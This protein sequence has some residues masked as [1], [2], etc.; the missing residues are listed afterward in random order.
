MPDWCA[1]TCVWEIVQPPHTHNTCK[2]QRQQQRGRR[3]PLADTLQVVHAIPN[4]QWPTAHASLRNTTRLGNYQGRL[5]AIRQGVAQH[6]GPRCVRRHLGHEQHK[7]CD[8]KQHWRQQHTHAGQ[9][10]ATW[11][12]KQ[13]QHVRGVNLFLANVVACIRH[14]SARKDTNLFF[15]HSV[16]L[17]QLEAIFRHGEQGVALVET[18]TLTQGPKLPPNTHTST[19]RTG[20]INR[21]FWSLRRSSEHTPGLASWHSL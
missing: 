14:I 9:R 2:R 4:A 20:V 17:P 12:G 13:Q 18:H 19:R 15:Q 16:D 21:A 5:E 10:A 1:R 6:K 11:R 3:R 8:Q 7:V